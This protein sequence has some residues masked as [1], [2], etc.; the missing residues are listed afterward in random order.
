MCTGTCGEA[1]GEPA[2]GDNCPPECGNRKDFGCGD[3][4]PLSHPVCSGEREKPLTSGTVA[5]WFPGIGT[6]GEKALSDF[7]R[8][9]TSR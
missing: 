5:E 3:K 9:K 6:C 7:G 1:D 8:A 4:C 2:Y